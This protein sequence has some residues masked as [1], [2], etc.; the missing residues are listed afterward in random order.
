VK[1]DL[2]QAQLLTINLQV[3]KRVIKMKKNLSILFLSIL[4]IY[5]ISAQ[6]EIH[7]SLNYF[8]E[9][10]N[11]KKIKDNFYIKNEHFKIIKKNKNPEKVDYLKGSKKNIVDFDNF[12]NI[13]QKIKVKNQEHGLLTV[14]KKNQIFSHIFLYQ[15]V[16]KIIYKYEVN[17]IDSILD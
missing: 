8:N 4:F 15:K 11:F 2:L 12:L 7:L 13:Y 17:W 5:K 6:D 16:D 10:N 14:L 9:K 3:T 1:E